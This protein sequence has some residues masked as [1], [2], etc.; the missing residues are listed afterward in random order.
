MERLTA[1][2]ES[3]Y[4]YFPQCYDEPCLGIGCADPDCEFLDLVC[5]KLAQYEERENA[6]FGSL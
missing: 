5:E 1:R 6:D 4:A 2:T 3:G